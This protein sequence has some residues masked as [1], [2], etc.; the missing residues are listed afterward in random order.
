MA[1]RAW[2]RLHLLQRVT[3]IFLR[4]PITA[5]NYV[6]QEN[7][8]YSSCHE[9]RPQAISNNWSNLP[10]FWGIFSL[11]GS[12]DSWCEV[13]GTVRLAPVLPQE[14]VMQPRG[15]DWNADKWHGHH[16]PASPIC[17]AFALTSAIQCT[18]F[19]LQSPVPGQ[20]EV[21]RIY[22]QKLREWTCSTLVPFLPRMDK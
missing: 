2:V 22:T 16:S 11:A 4:T 18:R 5:Y 10:V 13:L 7:S 6:F 14:P 20:A 15:W 1:I 19:W 8:Q 12:A 3:V 9:Q 17:P 21:R